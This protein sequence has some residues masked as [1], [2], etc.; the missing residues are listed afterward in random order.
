MT[1]RAVAAEC[2]GTGLLLYVVVGSG[3]TVD[4]L[5]AEPA[6]GLFFH[7]L[8]VGLVLTVLIVLFAAVSGAHFNPAVTLAVWR[9]HD[10]DALTAVRYVSAQVAGGVV[11]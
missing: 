5:N 8:A 4:R 11:G 2:A 1:R 10:L 9:R 6:S 3:L 7:A